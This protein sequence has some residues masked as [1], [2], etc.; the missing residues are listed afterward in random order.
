MENINWEKHLY[1]WCKNK[2]Y[3]MDNTFIR[4]RDMLRSILRRF[5]NL[6]TTPL[7]QIQEYTASIDNPNTRKNTLVVIRWAFDKVLHKPIDFRDLP[8]P[9]KTIKIQHI[10]THD[11]SISVLGATKNPK[12]KSIL[13]LLID[14]GLRC[15]EPCKIL[16]VDCNMD[17]RKIILR[18]AKG[19]K[20]RV[21]FPSEFVWSLISGYLE[22]HWRTPVKYLFEGEKPKTPYTTSS[23]RQ[24]IERSCKIAN[25]EYKGVHAFR[26]FAGTWGVENGVPE[27]IVADKLGNT[28]K[29][30]HKHYLIHSPIYLKSIPSPLQSVRA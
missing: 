8:Y 10:Y 20:D 18:S 26:R 6:E 16:I 21:I 25:V 23:I 4:Y 24:F 22:S 1:L 17:E 13:A 9:K 14:C 2:D 3:S 30:L 29:T 7:I 15:S 28:V 27:T 11:E 19:K 5:P 12:Q